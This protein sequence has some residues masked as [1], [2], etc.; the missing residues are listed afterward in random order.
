[1]YCRMVIGEV[2]TDDQIQEFQTIYKELETDILKQSGSKTACLLMEDGGT[3]VVIFT[4]WDSREYCL[5]YHTSKEYFRL[6]A[7]TQRLLIGEFVVK[8]FRMD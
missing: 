2:F 1:M 4:T 7:R 6:V 5:K 8:S 3:L